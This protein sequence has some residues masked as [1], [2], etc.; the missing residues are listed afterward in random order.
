MKYIDSFMIRIWPNSSILTQVN[1]K[2]HLYCI[3]SA[4]FIPWTGT[5]VRFQGGADNLPYQLT[6]H[7]TSPVVTE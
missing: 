4:S 3:V 7:S 5:E 6:H 2:R 1:I